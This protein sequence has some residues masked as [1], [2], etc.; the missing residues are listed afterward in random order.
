[1]EA[2]IRRDGERLRELQRE[3]ARVPPSVEAGHV[4]LRVEEVTDPVEIRVLEG[5]IAGG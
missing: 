1:M 4:E 3:A 5:Q 2:A